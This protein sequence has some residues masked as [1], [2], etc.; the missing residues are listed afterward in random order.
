VQRQ[1]ADAHERE[2]DSLDALGDARERAGEQLDDLREKVASYALGRGGRELRVQKALAAQRKTNRDVHS[3]NLERQDAAYDVKVAEAALAST[4][5]DRAKDTAKLAKEEAKGVEGSDLV[6]AAKNRVGTRLEAVAD[7]E[8]SAAERRADSAR[9]VA[10]AERDSPTGSGRRESLAQNAR[11]R[12]RA[13]LADAKDA[14]AD[15]LQR[16]RR[17]VGAGRGSAGGAAAG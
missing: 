13:E 16:L 4:Q 12:R 10:D 2:Q 8:E 5:K 3:T 15:S 1:V 7:A 6:V 14:V 9:A 17:R 11:S